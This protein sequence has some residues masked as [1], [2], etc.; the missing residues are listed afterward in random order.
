MRPL[1]SSS[2]RQARASF[3]VSDIMIESRAMPSASLPVCSAEA[4]GS[5]QMAADIGSVAAKLRSGTVSG[6]WKPRM[7]PISCATAAS[8]S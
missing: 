7:W 8:K 6:W 4:H 5:W 1:R 2:E 3:L